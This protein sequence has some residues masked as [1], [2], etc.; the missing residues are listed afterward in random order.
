LRSYLQ[1]HFI[2]EKIS[3]NIFYLNLIKSKQFELWDADQELK[4][5]QHDLDREQRYRN[6]IER[7][8][9]QDFCVQ[10]MKKRH[11]SDLETTRVK[12]RIY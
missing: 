1:I 7:L 11:E 2:G 3:F 5:K 12:N 9:S 8:K 10:T 4:Q 6:I